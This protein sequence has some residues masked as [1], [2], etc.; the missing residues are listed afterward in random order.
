MKAIHEFLIISLIFT[1]I[2][3]AVIVSY[4]SGREDIMNQIVV[5]TLISFM[6]YYL[7][8][9]KGKLQERERRK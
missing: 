8:E 6:A 4:F 2:I 3:I 7:G 5:T 9:L 1:A